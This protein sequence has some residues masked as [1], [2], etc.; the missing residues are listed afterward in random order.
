MG[1]RGTDQ[2][3]PC[4]TYEG[5]REYYGRAYLKEETPDEK[6]MLDGPKPTAKPEDKT[7]NID[8]GH[9]IDIDGLSTTK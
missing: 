8:I 2:W 3:R 1:I 9:P 6:K 7:G 5:G 4:T